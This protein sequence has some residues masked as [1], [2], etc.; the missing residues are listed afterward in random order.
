MLIFA[1][2]ATRG[3]SVPTLMA[4]VTADNFAGGVAGTTFI[5]YLSGLTSARFTATQYALL[6]SL[7]V[8]LPKLMAGGSGLVV[9]A[10]GYP[11]F[12]IAAALLGVP[13]VA[14]ALLVT[15]IGERP[16]RGSNR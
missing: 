11:S 8:L 3:H 13:V 12:F 1:W 9:N 16:H 14:L 10:I 5:A 6:S 7:M 2:L 15:R 4:A